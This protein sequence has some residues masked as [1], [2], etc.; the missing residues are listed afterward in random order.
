MKK[1]PKY[2]LVKRHPRGKKKSQR[3]SVAEAQNQILGE[4][5]KKIKLEKLNS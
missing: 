5:K 1:T 2:G 4:K 3:E